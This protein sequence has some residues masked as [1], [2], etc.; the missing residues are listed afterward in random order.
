M[1]F[2]FNQA[3]L[4]LFEL[5]EVNNVEVQMVLFIYHKSLEEK[6]HFRSR[7]L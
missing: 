6:I 2:T 5:I 7:L 3:V 4:K 1:M